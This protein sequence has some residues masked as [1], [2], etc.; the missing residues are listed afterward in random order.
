VPLRLDGRNDSCG[1]VV[2][3]AVPGFRLGRYGE[4]RD[5][6]LRAATSEGQARHES[7]PAGPF[8][9]SR[10]RSRRVR[11]LCLWPS[12]VILRGQRGEHLD[13][14]PICATCLSVLHIIRSTKSTR[15]YRGM[16]P[17]RSHPC[18][19]Q[20]RD[21]RRLRR[22]SPTDRHLCKICGARPTPMARCPLSLANT[23]TG[24]ASVR[25]KSSGTAQEIAR[26]HW[27]LCRFYAPASWNR[28]KAT[29]A[30]GRN[31]SSCRN[32]QTLPRCAFRSSPSRFRILQ[33]RWLGTHWQTNQRR[34]G[35]SGA[36]SQLDAMPSRHIDRTLTV[37]S[38]SDRIIV[39]R[40]VVKHGRQEA[41]NRLTPQEELGS[42][43]R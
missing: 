24:S 37:D 41:A 21:L 12:R 5:T 19:W 6:A 17:H 8:G 25:R 30:R 29:L 15:C 33:I 14:E 18:D 28:E 10:R 35:D 7:G 39:R 4:H 9:S 23:Q 2:H 22:L 40:S 1:A 31:N 27:P 20:H 26:D 16:R 11:W 32:H 42:T 3:G 13:S 36:A 38:M 43:G 34:S